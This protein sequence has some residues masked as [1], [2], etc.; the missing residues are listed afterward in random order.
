VLAAGY[1]L[2][3]AGLAAYGVAS[4]L[5]AFI[6][7]SVVAALGDLLLMGQSLAIVAGLAPASARA[8]YLAMFGLSWGAATVIAPLL[9]TAL[10]A[11]LG[12]AHIWGALGLCCLAL[13]AAQPALARRLSAPHRV[14]ACAVLPP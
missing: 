14:G 12:V 4:S 2:L 13:A 10:I 8:R 11:T 9:G 3:G 1:V 5:S 7:A 6:L